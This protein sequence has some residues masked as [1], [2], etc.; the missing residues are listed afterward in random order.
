MPFPSG[1]LNPHPKSPLKLSHN[2][3]VR[4]EKLDW[5][6]KHTK[7]FGAILKIHAVSFREGSVDFDI[8]KG[9][10]IGAI[11]HTGLEFNPDHNIWVV[12]I[13]TVNPAQEEREDIS[14]LAKK[15]VRIHSRMP[16]LLAS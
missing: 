8:P 15:V 16:Y 14:S 7:V 2:K 11:A 3:F 10:S 5:W 1:Y 6:K 4:F 9:Y 12:S 13:L